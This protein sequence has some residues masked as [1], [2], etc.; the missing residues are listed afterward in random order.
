[1]DSRPREEGGGGA[2]GVVGAEREGKK[3]EAVAMG[4][5][6]FKP[7]QRPGGEGGDLDVGRHAM[8]GEGV[9]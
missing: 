1:V 2:R 6:P 4:R 3:E 8:N 5:R 9:P 7:A